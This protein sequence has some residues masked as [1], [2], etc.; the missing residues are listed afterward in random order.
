[1]APT[2]HLYQWLNRSVAM[3]TSEVC[4]Y[5]DSLVFPVFLICSM[6]MLSRVWLKLQTLS[7]SLRRR[8]MCPLWWLRCVCVCVCVRACVCVCVR[9]CV[10]VC[11]RV[12]VCMLCVHVCTYGQMVLV[13]CLCWYTFT[14]P[15]NTHMWCV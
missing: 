12:C 6:L 14:C 11:V 5:H 1:M 3:T 8:E 4:G 13:G 15:C 10:C 9:V 2:L 7:F